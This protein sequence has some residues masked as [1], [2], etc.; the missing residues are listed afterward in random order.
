[1][2]MMGNRKSGQ[3]MCGR[4]KVWGSKVKG[5]GASSRLR[6]LIFA[7]NYNDS[8]PPRTHHVSQVCVFR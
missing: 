5:A 1:M 7:T 6:A 2:V 8:Y 3:A 4:S